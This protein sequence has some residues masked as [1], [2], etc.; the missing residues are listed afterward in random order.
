MDVSSYNGQEILPPALR[1]FDEKGRITLEPG[2]LGA[3]LL[4]L[5]RIM[6]NGSVDI[7]WE[8][9]RGSKGFSRGLN[10]VSVIIVHYIK[11]SPISW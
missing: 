8:V 10:I 1:R 7:P 4:G 6:I 5:V 11:E 9:F 3:D 2:C